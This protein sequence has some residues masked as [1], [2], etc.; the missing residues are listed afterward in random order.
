MPAEETYKIA[1]AVA[2]E[3]GARSYELLA[4]RALAKLC[5]LTRRPAEAKAVLASALERFSPTPEMPA[6]AEAQAL[7]ER[8]AQGP[9]GWR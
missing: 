3:Q 2:K 5:Q 1:I 7:M 8:L 6:I 4:A 9:F